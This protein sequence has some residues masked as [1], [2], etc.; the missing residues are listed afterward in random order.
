MEDITNNTSFELIKA[1]AKQS[2]RLVYA[3]QS[4]WWK[5][6]DPIYTHPDG[7][8]PCGPRREMLLETDDPLGFIEQAEKNVEHYGKHGLRAFIAAYHGNVIVYETGFPT[9]FDTW[10]KYNDIIDEADGIGSKNKYMDMNND[11]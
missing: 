6:G 2:N 9:S 8:L 5:I 10:D 7:G 1:L 11:F 3:V 4:C